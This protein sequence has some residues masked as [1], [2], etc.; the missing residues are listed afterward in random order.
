MS[1]RKKHRAEK[2]KYVAPKRKTGKLWLMAL[3][4]VGVVVLL[5]IGLRPFNP[6]PEPPTASRIASEPAFAPTNHLLP[7][8]PPATIPEPMVASNFAA[9]SDTE[10]AAYYQNFG[11]HLLE[12]GRFADAIAQYRMAVKL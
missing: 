11:S 12:K 7:L 8:T 1:R 3:V 9:L 6:N 5:A 10:K 4:A 2:R